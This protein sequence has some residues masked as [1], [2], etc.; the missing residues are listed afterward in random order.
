MDADRIR[1]LIITSICTDDELFR[2][3]VLKGGN[4]LSLVHGVGARAS[5]DVDFSMA[6]DFSDLAAA[7]AKLEHA[8]RVGLSAAGLELFDFSLQPRPKSRGGKDFD[9]GGYRAQ[10]KVISSATASTVG[11]DLH[12][13]RMHAQL[14]A[15]PQSSPQFVVDIS[16]YEFCDDPDELE[17]DGTPVRVYTLPMIACEKLRAICQQMDEY[18]LR[19][20]RA[21]RARDFYDIFEIVQAR[22]LDLSTPDNLELLREVFNAKK[23]PLHLIRQI[24]NSREFHEV[25]W[26]AV[27]LTISNPEEFS[28]YFD[29]VSRYVQRL[30]PLWI[31]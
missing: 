10:F 15:G 31:K 29:F 4:A 1:R 30:E 20:N 16:K 12:R 19:T 5:L 28:F 25:D 14:V 21:P 13:R 27:R 2:I 22:A 7:R 8:L 3:F 24:P 11:A 9:W 6:S 23:V 26:A 18:P 17:L